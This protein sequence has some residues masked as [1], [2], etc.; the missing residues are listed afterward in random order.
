M[1]TNARLRNES[2][3]CWL[4]RSN[5][6]DGVHCTGLAEWRERQGPR[7]ARHFDAKKPLSLLRGVAVDWE[8]G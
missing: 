1:V 4:L 3:M 6:K 5:A 7:E 8:T 2:L